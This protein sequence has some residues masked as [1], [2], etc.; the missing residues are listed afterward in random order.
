M[1]NNHWEEEPENHMFS[2][3]P[4]LNRDVMETA[5]EM[6]AEKANKKP[7]VLHLISIFLWKVFK[8][9]VIKPIKTIIRRK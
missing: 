5:I 7:S 2:D 6:M 9:I 4:G 3:C 1:F 8:L